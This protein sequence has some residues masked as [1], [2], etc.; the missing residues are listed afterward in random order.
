MT[1]RDQDKSTESDS[2]R[3]LS[4]SLSVGRITEAEAEV[5]RHFFSAKVIDKW[6]ASDLQRRMQSSGG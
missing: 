3:H 4:E 2:N 1:K 6:P 5:I